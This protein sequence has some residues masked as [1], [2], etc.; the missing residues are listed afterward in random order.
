MV[1]KHEIDEL[2]DNMSLETFSK[3]NALLEAI[4]IVNEEC[5]DREI[6]FETINL[7]PLYIKKF[8]DKRSDQ[9][10][11]RFEVELKKP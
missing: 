2:V 11:Q 10:H 9:I 3:W 6:D 1:T 5:N 4:G 7:E 8:V